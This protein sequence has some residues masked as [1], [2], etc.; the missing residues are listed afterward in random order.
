[1]EIIKKTKFTTFPVTEGDNNLVGIV[2]LVDILG[3]V[4][5]GSREMAKAFKGEH[6]REID[7]LAKDVDFLWKDEFVLMSKKKVRSGRA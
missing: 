3:T 4:R 7:N 1:M 2:T 6:L 5:R